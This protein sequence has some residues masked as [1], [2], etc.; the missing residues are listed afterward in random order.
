MLSLGTF[1]ILGDASFLGNPVARNIASLCFCVIVILLLG[2][3]KVGN[4]VSCLLGQCSYEIFLV[5]L[6]VLRLF[7]KVE[8]SSQLIYSAVCISIS[9]A[10][11]GILHWILKKTLYR[12][13]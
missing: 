13:C 7:L 6:F 1:Y 9:L 8:F 2:R 5:H 11:A 4:R 10:T 3:F 12:V